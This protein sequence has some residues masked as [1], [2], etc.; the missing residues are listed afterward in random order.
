MKTR[1]QDYTFDASAQTITFDGYDRI[2]RDAI[3]LIVNTTDN[4]IIYN[5]TDPAKGGSVATN[6]LTVRHD[7][8]DMSDTD[9][10]LIMY[11]TPVSAKN[12]SYEDSS[13]V[14]G[15]SP[16]THDVNTDLG[17]NAELGY[18]VC[19]GAGDITVNLSQDG[20]TYGDNITIKQ[21]DVLNLD[22]LDVDSIKMT[23]SGTDSS[24]RI[25]VW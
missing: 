19:D 8:T 9:D 15:D 13:F 25:A 22:G 24:Y 2:N 4:E 18:I 11:E 17:K 20:T 14:A 12:Q 16:A 3:L 7:T 23:H 21:D 1:I 6:V 5:L 10:L